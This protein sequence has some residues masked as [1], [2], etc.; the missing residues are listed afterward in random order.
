MFDNVL[1]TLGR[2]ATRYPATWIYSFAFAGMALAITLYGWLGWAIGSAIGAPMTTQ[3]LAL[4]AYGF[5]FVG[6]IPQLN[7]ICELQIATLRELASLI[8][9]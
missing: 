5:W 6:A 7:A 4:A 1:S 9:E 3:Y 8:E 2:I